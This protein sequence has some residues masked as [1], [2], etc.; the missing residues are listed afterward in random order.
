MS[1][2][3]QPNAGISTHKHKNRS[4]RIQGINKTGRATARTN[5]SFCSHADLADNVPQI[6]QNTY[7]PLEGPQTG[8]NALFLSLTLA[9]CGGSDGESRLDNFEPPIDTET[10]SGEE[11]DG[12]ETDTQ[13]QMGSGS[14]SSFTPGEIATDVQ[15]GASLSAGGSTNLYLTL[16]D[17]SGDLVNQTVFVTFNSSCL[18]T[19]G[20]RLV[21]L[22]ED[23][24]QALSTTGSVSVTYQATGCVG[25][26]K[27]VAEASTEEGAEINSAEVTLNVAQDTLDQIQF[28]DATP[29]SIGIR[30]MGAEVTSSE[31]RFRVVGANGSPMREIPVTFAL[32]KN[33][34]AGTSLAS[35]SATSNAEGYVTARVRSGSGAGIVNV[36]ATANNVSTLSRQ[37]VITTTIP[38]QRHSSLSTTNFQPVAWRTDGIETTM[39]IRL[40]D[41]N[42]NHIPAGT[43]VYFTASAGVIE[44][45]CLTAENSSCSVTW[46]SQGQR[47]LGAGGVTL[48]ENTPYV[49]CPDGNECRAGRVYVLATTEGNESFIDINSNGVFDPDTDLFATEGNCSPSVPVS[50]IPPAPID[51]ACDDLGPT[52]LDTNFNGIK[53]NDEIV[54]DP[55]ERNNLYNGILCR[56]EDDAAGVCSRDPITI[57]K[58]TMLVMASPY[59]YNSIPGLPSSVELSLGETALYNL[60]IADENG[61]GMPAGT[62]IEI[63]EDLVEN[64]TFTLSSDTIGASTE[65]TRISLQLKAD[66]TEPASGA[67]FFSLI[68]EGSESTFGPIDITSP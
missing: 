59:S 15:S 35:D 19:G 12:E 55:K 13:I 22:P 54:R 28:V 8:A 34:P 49:T 51:E 11:E 14:G 40:G 18:S 64:V 67:F 16:V 17:D 62:Q 37:L 63:N 9:A 38:T 45:E 26:D 36:M 52:Y 21:G 20:A 1:A 42:N 7:N 68:Y 53:D 25:E 48:Q 10:P 32:S 23:S 4:F 2:N 30:G 44:G 29:T 46:T 3:W 27:V 56:S 61:N 60:L 31:V 24:D 66:D 41:Q 39:T 33:A 47:P 43:A 50:Y 58:S 57:R 65:P 6:P 5:R